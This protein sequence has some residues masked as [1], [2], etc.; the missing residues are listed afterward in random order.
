MRPRPTGV[1]DLP[2]G[3]ERIVRLG[4]EM[5]VLTVFAFFPMATGKWM[6][7]LDRALSERQREAVRSFVDFGLVHV[8]LAPGGELLH[9]HRPVAPRHRRRPRAPLPLRAL[10]HRQP[11]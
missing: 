6:A 10:R 7:Q 4:R 2:E 8:E 9:L 1:E 3:L 11:A 5:D